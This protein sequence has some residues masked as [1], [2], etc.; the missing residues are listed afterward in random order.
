[1]SKA[2]FIDEMGVGFREHYHASFSLQTLSSLLS[3]G[4]FFMELSFC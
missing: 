2:V 3:F 4:K 1:M